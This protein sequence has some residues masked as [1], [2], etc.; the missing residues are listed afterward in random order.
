M[1]TIYRPVKKLTAIALLLLAA[2]ALSSC[3]EESIAN[4]ERGSVP[5]DVKPLVEEINKLKA[6]QANPAEP[7]MIAIGI[8]QS[9]SMEDARVQ[10]TNFKDFQTL[11]QKLEAR[12]GEIA[13]SAICD[14]SNR[15]LVRVLIPHPPQLNP[16]LTLPNPPAPL[17]KDG[18]PFEKD[19]REQAY[20]KTMADYNPQV[21]AVRQQLEVYKKSMAEHQQTIKQVIA[22][23]SPQ[24][25]SILKSPR[26]CQSTDIQN[27]IDR[28]NLF[29]KEPSDRWQKK[30]KRF[31][32]FITDG[33]DSFSMTPT[34]LAADTRVVVVNGSK[35]VG[36][37]DKIKHERF[38][39]PKEA[40]RHLAGLL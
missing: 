38:E 29:F 27:S 15:P 11:L 18:N 35:S 36:I 19:E 37:F 8:D 40:I 26:N 13:F 9:G 4:Q 20:A 39:S 24:I 7:V 32:L 6:Q 1:N 2:I 5:D 33:L 14:R 23:Q 25:E 31:A 16:T 34:N 3:K 10:D 12:G 22:K 30:P 28:A 21:E 17:S